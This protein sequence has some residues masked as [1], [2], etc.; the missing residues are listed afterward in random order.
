MRENEELI[1]DLKLAYM[2]LKHDGY[3]DWCYIQMAIFK[4]IEVLEKDILSETTIVTK[5]AGE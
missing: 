1:S 5:E 3:K 2:Y 4:A